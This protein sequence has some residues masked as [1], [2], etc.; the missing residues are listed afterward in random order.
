MLLFLLLIFL[1]LLSSLNYCSGDS[2]KITLTILAYSASTVVGLFE[3]TD[4]FE[5]LTDPSLDTGRALC[6]VRGA[7]S[8]SVTATVKFCESTNTDVLAEVY[9]TGDGSCL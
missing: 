9:V 5:G 6:V 7:V 2:V 3:D 4:F 1:F 8:S